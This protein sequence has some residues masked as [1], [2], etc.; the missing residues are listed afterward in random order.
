MPTARRLGAAS[1]AGGRARAPPPRRP[2]RRAG[3]SAATSSGPASA[4]PCVRDPRAWAP[5]TG[6]SSTPSG[7]RRAPDNPAVIADRPPR[8]PRPDRRSDG[9]WLARSERDEQRRGGPRVPRRYDQPRR[10]LR[11]AP[12][13]DDGPRA[14]VQRGAH[15]ARRRTRSAACWASSTRRPTSRSASRRR[16]TFGCSGRRSDGLGSDRGAVVM[17]DPTTGEILALASTPVVRRATASRTRTPPSATFDGLHRRRRTRS[18]PG[19]RSGATCPGS[20]FKIV[21]GDRGPRQRPRSRPTTT[22]PQQPAA[23]EKGLARRRLPDPRRPSP[24]DGRHALDLTGATEVSCNIWYALA[25][26]ADGRRPARRRGGPAGL[27]RAA[28]RST[29]RRPSSQV[30]GGDG[31]APAASRRR[32]ARVGLVRAGRDVRHARSRWRSWRRRSRTTACS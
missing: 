9:R 21:T 13:R 25:G 16:S 1:G 19:R 6:R 31:G 3:R 8:A 26:L 4:S 28:S 23:E 15:R 22:F 10:G 32:R 20:V 29:S 12:V 7:C 24:E 27:R 17:L 18:C 30:T 11:L 2:A 5:A 14:D